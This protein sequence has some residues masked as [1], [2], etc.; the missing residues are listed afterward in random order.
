MA[1]RDFTEEQVAIRD[2]VRAVARDRVA[3]RAAEID[4]TGEYPYDM[5]EL[6]QEL[7]LFALPF[8]ASY[9]GT[10]SLL[11]SCMAVEELNRVCY[12]TAYLLVLQ[13][14]PAAALKA[15][16]T[17]EQ[18]ERFLG[19][20]ATG[21][22]RGSL[23]LTEAQSGS[24]VAGTRTRAR[25]VDGGFVL[26]GNKI[27]CSGADLADFVLVAAKVVEADGNDSAINLFIV[28]RGME[29]FSVAG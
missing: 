18:Q 16:G 19:G 1:T 21:A 6:L 10:G 9:G 23:A 20:L 17:E 26:D 13:W 4:R 3:P 12:N 15:A 25:R 5:F 11:T 7:E 14:L 22:T 27:W 28:E 2:L 24:D 29:G 8:D